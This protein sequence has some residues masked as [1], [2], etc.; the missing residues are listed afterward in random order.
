[1]KIPVNKLLKLDTRKLP[2]IVFS[3]IEKRGKKKTINEQN[4]YKSWE[5]FGK[6]GRDPQNLYSLLGNFAN[7]K[8]WNEPLAIARMREDW[9]KIV[10]KSASLNCYIDQIKDGILI[11]RT[12][13]NVWYTQLSYCKP[14]LEKKIFE[15]SKNINIKEV[16]IVGPSLQ[17]TGKKS[18]NSRFNIKNH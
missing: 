16:K 18:I 6:P 10:G 11:V 9:W 12:K 2:E 15:Y 5:S 4:A 8:H 3:P 13:S 17:K 7:K 1:M 14:M